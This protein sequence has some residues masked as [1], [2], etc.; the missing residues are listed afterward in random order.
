MNYHKNSKDRR[1]CSTCGHPAS[2]RQSAKHMG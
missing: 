1:C 2:R